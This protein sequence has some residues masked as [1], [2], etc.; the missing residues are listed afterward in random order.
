MLYVESDFLFTALA[1]YEV[2]IFTFMAELGFETAYISTFDRVIDHAQTGEPSTYFSAFLTFMQ[3]HLHKMLN[4]QGELSDADFAR[5]ITV[6]KQA[7]GNYTERESQHNTLKKWRSH[8]QL[9]PDS[10]GY[11]HKYLPSNK[12][13]RQFIKRLLNN[14]DEGNQ[15]II[16]IHCKVA[17]AMDKLRQQWLVQADSS[18]STAEKSV[19]IVDDVF[20]H[21]QDHFKRCRAKHVATKLINHT[22]E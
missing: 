10:S 15:E 19:A 17:I 22:T 1:H 4:T 14:K 6:D 21:Y 11:T 2:G 20:K 5:C 8:W 13:L 3:Q 12:K 7:Y 9:K 18:S 16:F